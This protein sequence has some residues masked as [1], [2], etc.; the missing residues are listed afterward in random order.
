MEE[1][2]IKEIEPKVLEQSSDDLQV[3]DDLVKTP[4]DQK[5]FTKVKVN[6]RRA[7][8][9]RRQSDKPKDDF[10]QKVLDLARVTRVMA[11]GKRMKFRATMVIGDKKGKVG[12]GIA[13]GMDV[14]M[15]ISK[16]VSKA[17]KNL[18]E[19]PIIDGTVPHQVRINDHSA[20]LMI[21]PARSG[22]GI[23]AGGV[24]RIVFELAGIKDVVAKI[25]GT[26]NK[27]NNAKATVKALNS[28]IPQAVEAARASKKA[29]AQP[30]TYSA[31]NQNRG[32]FVRKD[33]PT[34]HKKDRGES[35]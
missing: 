25:L 3:I 20:K 10:E 19:V 5:V 28:F 11:G 31:H 7:P 9:K 29:P 17:R 27:V 12:I 24:M 33:K 32:A 16:A 30:A 21:R 4:A 15:A 23:K 2:N 22:S 8:I 26:S 18:V 1:K 13:K 35:K 6:F 14:S 34:G